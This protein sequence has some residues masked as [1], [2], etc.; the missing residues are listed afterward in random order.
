MMCSARAPS[1][2][3]FPSRFSHTPGKSR[4]AS[5]SLLFQQCEEPLVHLPPRGLPNK[6]PVPLPGGGP[7]GR[8]LLGGGPPGL[9]IPGG[10]LPGGPIGLGL[11]PGG[12]IGL[13]GPGLFMGGLLPGGPI[14][15]GY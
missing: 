9:T 11:L 2:R 13:G 10:M 6:L 4:N 3:Y 1:C 15:L 14:G 8:T 7:P 5:L 12:P